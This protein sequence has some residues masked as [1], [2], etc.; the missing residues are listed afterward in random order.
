MPRGVTSGGVGPAAGAAALQAQ[1]ELQAEIAATAPPPM[2][3]PGYSMQFHGKWSNPPGWRGRWLW[4]DATIVEQPPPAYV[5]V[6]AGYDEKGQ[7]IAKRV[8]PPLHLQR[9]RQFPKLIFVANHKEYVDKVG[10]ERWV[11]AER[12]MPDDVREM[13]LDAYYGD[14][15]CA[16]KGCAEC[17][18]HSNLT[19]AMRV[20]CAEQIRRREKKAEA[21]PAVTPRTL[22]QPGRAKAAT[23]PRRK[24]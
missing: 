14:P 13:L 10:K 20:I 3:G 23:K 22:Q 18:T 24:P 17:R 9:V 19:P 6:P 21:R 4:A 2:S 8:R 15:E 16:R 1:R 7:P 11:D 5:A 12:D